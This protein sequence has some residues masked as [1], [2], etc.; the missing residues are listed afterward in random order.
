MLLILTPLMW[1]AQQSS[2]NAPSLTDEQIKAIIAEKK[3][4]N[5]EELPDPLPDYETEVRRNGCNYTYI[6][7]STRGTNIY[8]INKNGN[9]IDIV[10]SN[11]PYML[12]KGNKPFSWCA[13]EN[14]LSEQELAIIVEKER[15]NN[16]NMKLPFSR[17]KVRVTRSGCGYMFWE[18]NDSEPADFNNFLIDP[19]GELMDARH[20][21]KR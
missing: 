3:V 4:K 15:K 10:S 7:H 17:Q 12:K 8:K 21:R 9:I 14:E 5:V 11:T 6:E 20:Y 16:R 2:C 18:E 19:S 1:G 13:Q